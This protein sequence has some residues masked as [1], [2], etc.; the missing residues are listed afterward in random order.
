MLQPVTEF[1]SIFLLIVIGVLEERIIPSNAKVPL[2]RIGYQ[3]K[4]VRTFERQG[5]VH[6]VQFEVN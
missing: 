2:W 5:R 1:S 3:L 4:E 6:R